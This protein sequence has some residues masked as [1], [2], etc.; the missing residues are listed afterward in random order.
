MQ[1]EHFSLIFGVFF[2]LQFLCLLHLVHVADTQINHVQVTDRTLQQKT[3]QI[4][5][6]CLF[7]VLQICKYFFI[8][9]NETVRLSVYRI[10]MFL[11]LLLLDR[12]ED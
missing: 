5:R 7:L 9:T 1:I 3:S 8:E 10:S 6:L 4:Y 11:Q 2:F 12:E